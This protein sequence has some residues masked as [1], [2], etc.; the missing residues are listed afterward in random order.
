MAPSD[1]VDKQ[2][3]LARRCNT[4][5]SRLQ[6]E[7]GLGREVSAEGKTTGPTTIYGL[8]DNNT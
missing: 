5:L 1:L 3:P 6:R 8:A 4:R 7:L 2:R